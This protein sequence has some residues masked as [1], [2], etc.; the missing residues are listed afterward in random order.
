MKG[1][2]ITII[3]IAICILI[4]T[5]YVGMQIMFITTDNPDTFEVFLIE[6]GSYEDYWFHDGGADPL[7]FPVL[8]GEGRGRLF[9]LETSRRYDIILNR[10]EIGRYTFN[11]KINYLLT[12]VFRYTIHPIAN[13][14]LNKVLVE[15]NSLY[16]ILAISTELR[17]IVFIARAEESH[18]NV[19]PVMTFNSYLKAMYV[20]FDE[21]VSFYFDFYE[22]TYR[23]ED[24]L[25]RAGF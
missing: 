12:D 17:S 19:L 8:G 2:D 14:G 5:V 22:I 24:L 11:Q 21:V 13:R 10:Y 1:K 9:C 6:T 23:W 3:F 15:M 4:V 7:D 16:E 20:T 25:E 18:Y